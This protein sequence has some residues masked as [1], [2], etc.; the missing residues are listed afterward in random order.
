[1][2]LFC[3]R[4][5]I[6]KNENR[7][8]VK[9]SELR[10]LKIASVSSPTILNYLT[11]IIFE[12][13]LRF[14]DLSEVKHDTDAKV[15]F[16]KAQRNIKQLEVGDGLL[17]L[18]IL[19]HLQLEEFKGKFYAHQFRK[20]VAFF[21]S[22]EKLD[23][24]SIK[25]DERVQSNQMTQIMFSLK[26]V[27]K[28]NLEVGKFF[29]ETMRALSELRNL[30]DIEMEVNCDDQTVMANVEAL[31]S[32]VMPTMK[33]LTISNAFDD[34]FVEI[35]HQLVARL[36]QSFPML[37]EFNLNNVF[38]RD[39]NV[40]LNGLNNLEKLKFDLNDRS[41]RFEPQIIMYNSLKDIDIYRNVD[42][43]HEAFHS[44]INLC[45]VAPNLEFLKI[46]GAATIALNDQ[47]CEF[48]ESLSN[49]KS[50]HIDS[51]NLQENVSERFIQALKSVSKVP[52]VQ[53]MF[54][55]QPDEKERLV[56]AF[57]IILQFNEIDALEI[58]SNISKRQFNIH[59][60][61]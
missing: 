53:L 4:A 2:T 59:S 22:Q 31:T 42:T 61:N 32:A 11:E 17:N 20:L 26:N 44:I 21:N 15:K 48:F 55:T 37:K 54:E 36:G 7:K 27:K 58:G 14:L 57:N 19:H 39:Y 23:V 43:P 33:K 10:K 9:L 12:G 45:R 49:L 28:L 3:G 16:L 34:G 13:S 56:E 60:K 52:A 8:V 47:I 35:S 1:L 46:S 29:P 6:E 51:L 30:E 24:V 25:L 41:P 40:L 5:D 18:D 50:V 38:I